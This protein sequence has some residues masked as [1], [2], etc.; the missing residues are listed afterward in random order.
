MDKLS[1]LPNIGEKLEMQLISIGIESISQLESMG[2]KDVWFKLR[3][4]DPTACINRLYAIEGAIQ[5]KRWH[6]LSKE[7]KDDLKDFYNEWK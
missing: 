1:K 3:Q 6:S 5:R 4:I 7:V 2:S